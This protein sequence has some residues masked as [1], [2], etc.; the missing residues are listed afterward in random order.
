ME[1]PELYSGGLATDDRG[2]LTFNDAFDFQRAGIRRFYM[3][4]NHC[5][6]GIRAW[7]GHKKEAKY[8]TAVNGTFKIILRTMENTFVR[9]NRFEYILSA[10]TP[11]I[12]YVPAGYYNGLMSLTEGAQL[13]VYST[14]TFEESQDDDYREK[15]DFFDHLEWTVNPR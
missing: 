4:Q 10:T 7:H 13:M 2:L 14:T 1:K 15:Y 9:A 12:L 5:A 3:I 8:M 6:Y 11:K